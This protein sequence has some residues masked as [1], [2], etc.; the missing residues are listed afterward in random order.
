MLAAG[1][2][3]SDLPEALKRSNAAAKAPL[4]VPLILTHG[5]R[6]GRGVCPP[7]ARLRAPPSRRLPLK[8]GVISRG[9]QYHS[10]L[11]GESQ[12]PSRQAKADA[13]GGRTPGCSG[14]L[15]TSP[16]LRR[17]AANHSFFLQPFQLG[18]AEPPILQGSPGVLSR[19]G[20]GLLDPAGGAAFA[21]H[22]LDCGLRPLADSPSRGE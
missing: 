13:V 6:T 12:K 9:V 16:R 22:R 15:K 20:S 7:P 17:P 5:A 14:R 8:G 4:P 2:A 1:G 3:P 10:P 19:L 11:E 21:P 18:L